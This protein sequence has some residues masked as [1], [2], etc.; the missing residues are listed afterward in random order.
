[1]T[2]QHQTVAASMNKL[3]LLAFAVNSSLSHSPSSL[4]AVRARS[5]YAEDPNLSHETKQGVTRSFVRITPALE[6]S[7]SFAPS[8]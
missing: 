1:M 3:A 2:A 6:I 4:Y 5:T 7:S 8:T